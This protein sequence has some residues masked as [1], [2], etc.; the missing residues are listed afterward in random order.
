[1]MLFPKSETAKATEEL[2][3]EME[4]LK[5]QEKAEFSLPWLQQDDARLILFQELQRNLK[6]Y[7]ESL[8]LTERSH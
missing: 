1:M 5:Q 2:A 4:F 3:R 6:T 8:A 7:M